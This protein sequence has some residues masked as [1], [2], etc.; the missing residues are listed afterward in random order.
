MATILTPNTEHPYALLLVQDEKDKYN[1]VH[2]QNPLGE[3]SDYKKQTIVLVIYPL[4]NLHATNEFIATVQQTCMQYTAA[5]TLSI[6]EKMAHA[7]N[8]LIHHLPDKEFLYELNIYMKK[9]H[10]NQKV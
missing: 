1:L 10:C 3:A 7:H 4:L 2:S 6:V 5:T 8:L 9:Q